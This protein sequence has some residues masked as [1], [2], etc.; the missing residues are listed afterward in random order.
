MRRRP[1]GRAG[2]RHRC[3]QSLAES[4]RAYAGNEA[5]SRWAARLVTGVS[6]GAPALSGS[7]VAPTGYVGDAFR[8]DM[9]RMNFAGAN[10]AT[11]S[12]S[13]R[14]SF[15]AKGERDLAD[16]HHDA[17]ITIPCQSQAQGEITVSQPYTP[18]TNTEESRTLPPPPSVN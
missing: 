17:G 12:G 1:L 18:N 16:Y 7:S 13:E 4:I 15:P 6:R 5:A 3:I 8:T 11:V 2:S 14:L 10:G 9:L